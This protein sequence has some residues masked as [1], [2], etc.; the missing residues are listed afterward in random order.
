[1]KVLERRL[2]NQRQNK[3]FLNVPCESSAHKY[4]WM[5]PAT[6]IMKEWGGGAFQRFT[7]NLGFGSTSHPFQIQ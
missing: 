4:L 7:D 6:E 5:V 3:E 1:M 2:E